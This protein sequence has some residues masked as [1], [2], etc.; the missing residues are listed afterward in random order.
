MLVFVIFER[1]GRKSEFIFSVPKL[2]TQNPGAEPPPA[3]RVRHY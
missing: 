1:A 3:S 2:S